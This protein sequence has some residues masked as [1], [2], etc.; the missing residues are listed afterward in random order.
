MR[1]SSSSSSCAMELRASNDA[2]IAFYA[3]ATA[4]WE[5]RTLRI[6]V[7]TAFLEL[8]LLG[9]SIGRLAPKEYPFGASVPLATLVSWGVKRHRENQRRLHDHLS[10]AQFLLAGTKAQKTKILES[11]IA[12]KAKRSV[13]DLWAT[14]PAPPPRFLCET[15]QTGRGA[16]SRCSGCKTVARAR[17]QKSE[18]RDKGVVRK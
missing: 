16:H 4:R 17:C 10:Y 12:E 1:S 5:R 8:V 9:L 7:M 18:R 2:A 15:R 6:L 11:F 13:G 3:A 14:R